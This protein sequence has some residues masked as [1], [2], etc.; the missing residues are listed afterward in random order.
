MAFCSAGITNSAVIESLKFQ[1]MT[2][3]VNLPH[4]QIT[5]FTISQR[6]IRN[7]ANNH[8]AIAHYSILSVA[9]KFSDA[10]VAFE[11]VVF[12]LKLIA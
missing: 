3:L 4:C 7:V 2:R 10:N 8:L 11:S 1:P 5:P 9:K 12:G 6:E